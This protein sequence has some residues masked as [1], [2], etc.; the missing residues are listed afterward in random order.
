MPQ[1][2]TTYRDDYTS[3]GTSDDLSKATANLA[4][5]AEKNIDRAIEGA[6]H[7]A[8]SVNEAGAEASHRVQ[9]V[10]GN[11]AT[12]VDRSVKDQPTTTLLMAAALGFVIG[13][14]WKS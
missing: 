8:R 4:S 14:L 7:A 2:A 6:Q 12:A 5:T 1:S 11:F 3:R 13:A 10:A 9:E